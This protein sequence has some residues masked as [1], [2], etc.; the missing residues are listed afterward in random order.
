MYIPITIPIPNWKS[1]GFPIL[2][3]IP[4]QCGDSMSKRGQVRAISAGRVYLPSLPT[5]WV[6]LPSLV[7]T[8]SFANFFFF[9]CQVFSLSTAFLSY[10]IFLSVICSRAT[11]SSLTLTSCSL[12]FFFRDPVPTFR[13]LGKLSPTEYRPHP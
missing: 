4:S 7:V 6:Y 11:S 1:R 10:S 8:T 2:I 5:G 13:L 3:P 12:C 9:S